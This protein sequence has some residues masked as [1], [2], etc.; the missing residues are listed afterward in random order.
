MKIKTNN[1]PRKMLYGYQLT[2]EQKSDFDYVE[3]IDASDFVKYKGV[4]YSMGDF[5]LLGDNRTIDG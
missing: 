4:I 3:D 5:M 1:Q 2:D